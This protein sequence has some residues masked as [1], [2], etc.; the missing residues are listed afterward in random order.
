M[1][2]KIQLRRDSAANWTATN[3]VLAQGEPGLETDTN[4]IKYGDGTT[5]WNLL[6]YAAGGSGSGDYAA[7]FEDGINDNTYHFVKVQGKKEFT[8]ETEGYKVVEIT[9]TA[10][11]VANLVAD[12]DL[13]FTAADTPVMTAIWSQKDTYGNEV[14]VYSKL[15]YDA[16]NLN[17]YLNSMTSPTTGNFKMNVSSTSFQAGDKI[18]IRYWTEGTIYAGSYYDNYG[19]Y[20]PDVSESSAT[21]TVTISNVEFDWLGDGNSGSALYDLLDANA[22]SRHELVFVQQDNTDRRNITNVVNNNGVVTI[23]FDGAAVQSKTTETA[24]FSFL[25]VDAQ[26]NTS[27]MTLPVL[28]YPTFNAD[29]IQG[30]F[31]TTT[32]K[33]T[34][35]EDRSGYFTINGGSPIDFWWYGN[36]NNASQLYL[37]VIF[38]NI[39]YNEGDTIA[40]T[41][42]KAPTRLSLSIY[43]PGN[44]SNNWNNGYKWFDWKDDMAQEYSPAEG[45]GVMA[46]M[47]QL[48]MTTYR[49]PIGGWEANSR[50]L[51]IQF[52]WTNRGGYDR[53]PYDPYNDNNVTNWGYNQNS[54]YPMYDFNENGIIFWSNEN[55]NSLSVTYKVRIIYKFDLIIGED[56]GDD[57][58]C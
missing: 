43:R 25:A 21:N 51:P 7:G 55:Y 3:P 54:C 49:Q 42:Y 50:S 20:V 47:G 44:L 37:N 1:S 56:G 41:F 32:D 48:L 58:F 17:N 28:A 12:S 38:S 18:V 2:S 30:G 36:T 14:S 9:L 22:L 11:M 40:V 57:W 27:N 39:S 4:K 16:N 34:G 23:T 26:T 15:D 33:Y 29:C 46:G 8:F 24:S 5:A 19:D 52:G 35:G 10:P 45:N 13:T 53:S 6:D 31:G